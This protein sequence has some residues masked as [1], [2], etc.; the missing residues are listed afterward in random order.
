MQYAAE[1]HTQIPLEKGHKREDALE[2]L[3]EHY[4]EIIADPSGTDNPESYFSPEEAA[5]L[6]R[7]KEIADSNVDKTGKLGPDGKPLLDPWPNAV[8]MTHKDIPHTPFYKRHQKPVDTAIR[9]ANGKQIVGY[10][11]G[12]LNVAHLEAPVF[13][14]SDGLLRMQIQPRGSSHGH[15]GRRHVTRSYSGYC[16]LPDPE[17][18]YPVL[19]N[20][21][22]V[23]VKYKH[24][25]TNTLLVELKRRGMNIPKP[26]IDRDK[27]LEELLARENR[28]KQEAEA[29]RVEA[30][31]R[32]EAVRVAAR[33]Q[34]SRAQE[35][36]QRGT[37]KKKTRPTPPPKQRPTKRK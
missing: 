10:R 30:L 28:E 21:E 7:L 6:P 22:H 27:L 37:T 24:N 13:L 26:E 15:G 9:D 18:L 16:R 2:E 4:N 33:A 34:A 3:F 19:D 12:F 29:K 36:A 17:L 25:Q 11:V 1:L 31:L 35:E 32:E 5:F 14:C 8:P 20:G 23:A